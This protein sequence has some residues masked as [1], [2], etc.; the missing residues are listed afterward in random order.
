MTYCQRAKKGGIY[1]GCAKKW[2]KERMPPYDIPEY[3]AMAE[4]LPIGW[5][6]ITAQEMNMLLE[7]LKKVIAK[8]KNEKL[9]IPNKG[10]EKLLKSLAQIA[11]LG[12]STAATLLVESGLGI[13]PDKDEKAKIQAKEFSFE[14]VLHLINGT[15]FLNRIFRNI[16]E[17]MH[18][19][20]KDQELIA[21]VLTLAAIFLA[22]LAA[23]NGNEDRL[24][25]LITSFRHLFSKGLTK[26]EH[27]VSDKLAN[28]AIRGEKAQHAAMFLQQARIALEKE[29]FDG[30]YEAFTG[31]IEILQ[32]APDD[33]IDDVKEIRVYA[34][35][36]HSAIQSSLNDNSNQVTAMSQSM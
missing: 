15:G 36:L 28:E 8:R 25:S 16:A 35:K 22:I 3:Q 5:E 32:I 11:F 13:L 31:S 10:S 29:D 14:L 7:S 4:R 26:V 30:F 1:E 23:S 17:T 20:K 24:K 34:K 21:E 9:D 19:S 27:F 12:I 2:A 18:T 33:F 6:E